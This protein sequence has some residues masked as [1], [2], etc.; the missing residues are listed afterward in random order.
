M[1]APIAD[2]AFEVNP[3]IPGLARTTKW[4]KALME[5]DLIGAER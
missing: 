5:K 2:G 3:K 4:W 1:M